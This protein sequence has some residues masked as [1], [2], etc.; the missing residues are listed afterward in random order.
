[1]TGANSV[2]WSISGASSVRP[3]RRNCIGD[4]D[5]PHALEKRTPDAVH[6]ARG[7][8][9]AG[10]D[11]RA[12]PSAALGVRG[13]RQRG[14]RL[15]TH[16]DE[17]DPGVLGGA[18]QV[19]VVPAARH[20]EEPVAAGTGQGTRDGGRELAARQTSSSTRSS[21]AG[22][23]LSGLGRR[24]GASPML[25]ASVRRRRGEAWAFGEPAP[26]ASRGPRGPG[27]QIAH[28]GTRD[29]GTT[30]L[31]PGLD[32]RH[33]EIVGVSERRVARLAATADIERH[34]LSRLA[35]MARNASRPRSRLATPTANSNGPMWPHS[36]RQS[37]PRGSRRPARCRR[38]ATTAS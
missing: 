7:P 2:A 26:P 12:E 9:P 18:D 35:P 33:V 5:E 10:D 4:D 29:R 21:R 8:R 24:D 17:L 19:E 28:P 16:E 20:A 25:E 34:G 37:G 15:A 1:M 36:P 13:G 30:H 32:E 27:R 6:D 14:G 23:E 11:A 3:P 38:P 31:V 22:R